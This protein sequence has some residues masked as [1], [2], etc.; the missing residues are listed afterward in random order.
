MI[1]NV[2]FHLILLL[3]LTTNPL[4]INANKTF[5]VDCWFL[6]TSQI[7]QNLENS[8][9]ELKD[10]KVKHNISLLVIVISLKKQ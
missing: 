8:I 2:D 7:L 9:L 5:L 10:S 1:V 6:K 4:L 3:F